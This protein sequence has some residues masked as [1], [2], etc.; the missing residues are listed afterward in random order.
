MVEEIRAEHLGMGDLVELPTVYGPE[1]IRVTVIKPR[2][3]GIKFKGLNGNGTTYSWGFEY[4]Q[5][6]RRLAAGPET[7]RPASG[8]RESELPPTGRTPPAEDS[9]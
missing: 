5:L 7:D 4:G 9:R 1:S 6:V 8:F 2:V 3:S